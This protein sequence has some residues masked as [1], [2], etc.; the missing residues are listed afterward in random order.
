MPINNPRADVTTLATPSR[1]ACAEPAHAAYRQTICNRN[2]HQCCRQCDRQP[3][4]ASPYLLP[5]V[6]PHCEGHIT[7][8]SNSAGQESVAKGA[9]QGWGGR[10]RARGASKPLHAASHGVAENAP[11]AAIL[12]AIITYASRRT[13]ATKKTAGIGAATPPNPATGAE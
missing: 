1:S 7:T 2:P 9:R 6:S 5:A 10:R 13:S 3:S 8:R 12:D 11:I 4:P